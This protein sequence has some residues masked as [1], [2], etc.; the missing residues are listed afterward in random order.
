[1]NKLIY[2]LSH[3]AH[4]LA[5]LIRK[6]WFLFPNDALFLSIVYYLEMGEKLNLKCPQ[7]FTEKLQW[8]KLY[9]RRPEYTHMVDKITAKVYAAKAIGEEFIIPTLGVWNHFDEIDFSRLPNK[10]VLKT[11]H[12]SGGGGVII[13]HD[14][15]SFD[16]NHARKILERSLHK[17]TYNQYREWPYKNITP[18]I[19]AEKLL[20][21]NSNETKSLNDYKF[22][23]FNGEPKLVM[24]SAGRYNNNLTFDYYDMHW[25]KLPLEW[26]K[27]NSEIEAPKPSNLADMIAV[28]KTLSKD[29][30]HVRVDLY[31][32]NNKIYFGEMTFYDASGYSKFNP[33]SWNRTL[34]DLL[35]LP[36]ELVINK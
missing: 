27:P 13:C 7:K 21:D 25:K 29:I 11:N 24:Y 19:F 31:S 36:N 32:V 15:T 8:L 10:F 12:G 30:P 5:G 35:N 34:G 23:C 33:A 28:C 18:K 14:K 4:S 3:P 1:M 17:N 6:F 9:D 16:Q 22:H 26:D 20:E 2:Q